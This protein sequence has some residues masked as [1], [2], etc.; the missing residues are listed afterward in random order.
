MKKALEKAGKSVR[1]IEY[2]GQAHGGWDSGSETRQIEDSIAFLK[3]FLDEPPNEA[4]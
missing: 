4:P 2:A 1:Y 3:P